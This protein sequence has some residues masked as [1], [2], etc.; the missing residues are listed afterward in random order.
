MH[1][2]ITKKG[3]Y[4]VIKMEGQIVTFAANYHVNPRVDNMS[5][6][7]RWVFSQN[8]YFVILL[9]LKNLF[10]I[11]IILTVQLYTFILKCLKPVSEFCHGNQIHVFK[12]T[13]DKRFKKEFGST[14][15]TMT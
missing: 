2:K 11:L 10:T 12:V 7:D 6:S 1:L 8:N 5:Q 4:S 3:V 14:M 15:T 13:P 9:S